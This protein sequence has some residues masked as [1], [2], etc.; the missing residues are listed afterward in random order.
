MAVNGVEDRLLDGY[1]PGGPVPPAAYIE[2][3]LKK[4]PADVKKRAAEFA[5]QRAGQAGN[6]DKKTQV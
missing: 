1:D 4:A 5:K 3:L 6:P 2:K